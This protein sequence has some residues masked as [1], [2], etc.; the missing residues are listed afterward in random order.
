MPDQEISSHEVE[1]DIQQD[2]Q[3]PDTT[4]P[5]DE[6]INWD[7]S[8]PLAVDEQV[9][10]SPLDFASCGIRSND[11]MTITTL[12]ANLQWDPASIGINVQEN[13]NN[14]DPSITDLSS[15][16]A[17]PGSA[18]PAPTRDD[19]TC[20]MC[21]KRLSTLSNR[22]RHVRTDCPLLAVARLRCQYSG[23][24]KVKKRRDNMAKHERSCGFRTEKAS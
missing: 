4:F 18:E 12:L 6:F 24:G 19:L 15:L 16:L 17:D 13:L 7:D 9:T 11:S 23:R 8:G 3:L 10:I 14:A 2:F 20:P 5:F 22:N 1:S 21:G